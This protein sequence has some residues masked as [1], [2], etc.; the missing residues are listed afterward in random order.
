MVHRLLVGWLVTLLLAACPGRPTG[1]GSELLIIVNAP[2]SRSPYIGRTI[3][4]GVRLAVDEINR[5]GGVTTAGRTYRF[6]VETLDNA[7]SPEKALRNIRTAVARNA[8]AVVDEG[9]GIN[10]AW[11]VANP[12]RLPICITFQ[13]GMGLV[14]AEARP[15]VFRIAPQDHGIGFRYA[16]YL[17]PKGL[18]VGFLHDDSDYGQQGRLAFHAAFGRNPEAV[19][20]EIGVPADAAD[21]S[22][23]VLQARRSGATAL[24]V[25][26]TSATVA[27]VV[28][29]ARSSG[30]K[31]PI[32]T[33]PTGQDPLV[34]Q[35]LSDHP[36]WVDGLTFASG[37]MTAERGPGPFLNFQGN[38]EREFG[39]DEVGVKT[40]SGRAV[41]Q[42]PEYAMYSYDFVNVLAAAVRAAA[43]PDRVRLLDALNQ[44]DVRG[45]NGDERGFNEKN[46]DGVVDDD[47]YFAV[48]HDMTF[49]PV[50][51]DPL[52]STLPVIK[53]T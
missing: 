51:D 36:E 14:D 49:S 25:W 48:F 20:A 11:R 7:L 45:A 29:T 15:N 30:W 44:V 33:P 12:A 6:R 27:S 19:T 24:L 34:R 38:Y 22:P 50:R 5:R 8:V 28:R 3:A 17:I 47:V 39:R 41:I 40:S 46:H 16:E 4:Q 43:G 23:Q 1:D 18:K 9:T 37:R 2:F 26:G 10:A 52:S 35:Q 13:G 42:P 31:V 53:Q 21:P 32:Y